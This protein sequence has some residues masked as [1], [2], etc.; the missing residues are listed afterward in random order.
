M[1][2]VNRVA[3]LACMLMISQAH[4]DV[5]TIDYTDSGWWSSLGV[6]SADNQNYL[7]GDSGGYVF[8][9]FFV[10][11]LSG[12]TGTIINASLKIYN[13]SINDA[14][15]NGQSGPLR[16]F[17]IFDVSTSIA[18]LTTT[19][20]GQFGIFDDLGTG[21]NLGNNNGPQVNG[22]IVTTSFNAAGLAYI[23]SGSGGLIA[24]GGSYVDATMNNYLFGYGGNN[25][26]HVRQLEITTAEV[27]AVPAPAG[28]VLAGMCIVSIAGFFMLRR[29]QTKVF[30]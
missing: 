1:F 4:A 9:N 7:L 28:V 29:R 14:P 19:G 24:F 26:N 13:P 23:Q 22:T 5:I 6:H 20:F 2:R 17:A 8:R 15:G 25:L 10:F 11:D 21:T 27:T 30:V 16:T 12:V 18:A 3:I